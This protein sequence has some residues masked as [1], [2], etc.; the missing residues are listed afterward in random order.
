MG[1][2]VS[3]VAVAV[4]LLEQK[5]KINKRQ[6]CRLAATIQYLKKIG[7]ISRIGCLVITPLLV[8]KDIKE[9]LVALQEK[10][11]KERITVYTDGS[12][13]PKGNMCNSGSSIIVTD[14]KDRTIWSGGM[15]VRADGNNF[16]PNW[17]LLRRQS[18]PVPLGCQ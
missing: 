7:V 18:K 11:K 6:K 10:D 12:T 3:E 5:N 17:L 2:P 1:L 13:N 4:T 14:S 15:T 8:A 9:T 16:I